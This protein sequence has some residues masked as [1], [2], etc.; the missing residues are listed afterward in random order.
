MSE[1]GAKENT[2]VE[3]LHD[4]ARESVE[5][6]RSTD[7]STVWYCLGQADYK[8]LRITLMEQD[9][10]TLREWDAQAARLRDELSRM[11]VWHESTGGNP[12]GALR[13]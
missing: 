4:E 3:A 10:E 6:T 5:E 7:R 1:S 11:L 12:Q 8:I 2:H 13:E 9:A